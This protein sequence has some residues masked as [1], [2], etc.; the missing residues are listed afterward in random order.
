ME[1]SDKDR[2]NIGMK[3]LLNICTPLVI[4]GALYYYYCP[5]VLFVKLLDK[6]FVPF[7]S[8]EI[9][10]DL[11]LLRCYIFDLLWAY[12]LFFSVYY[13]IGSELGLSKLLLI[14]ILF[15]TII[16]TIQLIPAIPG[17]FDPYDLLLEILLNLFVIKIIQISRR[18]NY[19]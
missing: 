3:I 15:E 9:V 6:I 7:H 19:E 18:N 4:G 10:T 16:E 1:V 11:P 13:F 8:T 12:S 5:D 17:T 14:V 2:S